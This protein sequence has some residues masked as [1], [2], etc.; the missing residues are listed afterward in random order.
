MNRRKRRLSDKLFGLL[1]TLPLMVIILGIFIYPICEVIRLSFTNQKIVGSSYKYIGLDNYASFLKDPLAKTSIYHSMVWVAENTVVQT[2]FGFVLALLLFYP[3][4]KWKSAQS[5]IIIPWIIPTVMMV[6]MWRWMLNASN[7]IVSHFAVKLGF[8]HEPINLLGTTS[9]AMHTLVDLNSWRWVPFIAIMIYA[10]LQNAPKEEYEAA[11]VEGANGWQVFRYVT[12]PN[13]AKTLFVMGLLGMLFSFNIFDLVFL[14]TNGGPVDSTTTLPILIYKL[15]FQ[16]YSMSKAATASIYMVVLL[17]IMI[18]AFIVTSK[19]LGIVFKWVAAGIDIIISKMPKKKSKAGRVRFTWIKWLIGIF[20]AVIV[21]GPLLWMM[22]ASLRTQA[23]LTGPFKLIPSKLTLENY[24]HLFTQTNY[25]TYLF[26]SIFVVFFAALITTVL[27]MH[28]AYA[29]NRF[30]FP[31][32][33]M[34]KNSLL[35]AYLFPNIVLLVPLFQVMKTLG[36]IDSLWCLVLVNVAF[37]APFCTWLLDSYM[38]QL[39]EEVEEAAQVEGAGRLTVLYRVVLPLLGPG[40]GSVIM[41]TLISAWSEYTFAISFIMDPKKNTLTSG[42][43]SLLSA[44]TLDW[45]ALSTGAVMVALPIVLFFAFL[46]RTLIKNATS[47]AIK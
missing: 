35:I 23:D 9:T 26:N 39:P 14:L 34:I 16:N 13:I 25:W 15:A 8:S 41:F 37:T 20:L 10:A 21:G 19:L 2:I 17:L 27:S 6:L 11:N 43:S 29:I 1:N 4:R 28:T 44:Y 38:K 30:A 7:G 31:G 18:I 24:V 40:I 47:G 5:F 45:P 46:G 33:K 22:L 42:L 36:L 3:L 32:K 12:I